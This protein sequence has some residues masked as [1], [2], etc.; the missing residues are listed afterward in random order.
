[1]KRCPFCAEEILD[2]AIRCKHCR[3]DLP[4]EAPESCL[5][6]RNDRPIATPQVTLADAALRCGSCGHLDVQRVATVYANGSWTSASHTTAAAIGVSGDDVALGGASLSTVSA[7]SSHL[8]AR[9]APPE[10]PK[11]RTPPVFFIAAACGI[12][13]L[14]FAIIWIGFALNGL[15]Y[16][17]AAPATILLGCLTGALA[18]S[19]ASQQ[20]ELDRHHE[21]LTEVWNDR[22]RTWNRLLFCPRCG[23][24]TD[25]ESG[26]HRSLAVSL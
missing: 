13:T 26:N 3:S 20:K 11:R 10:A 8:A 21:T 25:P 5:D 9:L 4:S 7:G 18:A 24:V 14:V 16:G 1:M 22:C 17:W 6:S 23:S 2:E 12:T 19:S 15:S